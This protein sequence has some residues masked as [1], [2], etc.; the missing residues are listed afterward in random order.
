[1]CGHAA[2][3]CSGLGRLPSPGQPGRRKQRP[4]AVSGHRDRVARRVGSRSGTS[5]DRS[6]TASLRASPRPARSSPVRRAA[7]AR[8]EVTCPSSG[9]TRGRTSFAPHSRE[10]PRHRTPGGS[11]LQQRDRL[12]ASYVVNQ[13]LEDQPLRSE[14]TLQRSD[15]DELVRCDHSKGTPTSRQ[16]L[17]DQG[18]DLVLEA[19][20][21]RGDDPVEVAGQ[22]CLELRVVAVHASRHVGGVVVD[23]VIR[24][25]EADGTAECPFVVG[26]R[27]AAAGV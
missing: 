14:S 16:Q 23:A 10:G 9:E 20:F 22:Q 8:L 19:E 21:G 17:S 26:D 2:E 1:M 27:Q 12:L 18:H 24:L 3:Q 6:S 4:A 7:P 25:S 15:T 13:T 5:I 11:G